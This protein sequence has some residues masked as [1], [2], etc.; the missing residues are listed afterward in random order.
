MK[1]EKIEDKRYTAYREFGTKTICG[2]KI[3][4]DNMGRKIVVMT[5]LKDNPGMSITNC[6]EHLATQIKQDFLS[7]TISTEI[8]WIEHYPK[9]NSIGESWDVVIMEWLGDKFGIASWKRLDN[10]EMIDNL[11]V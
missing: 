11:K 8:V 3:F 2:L 5:E 7:K 4:R 1:L 10:K 6:V 9:S